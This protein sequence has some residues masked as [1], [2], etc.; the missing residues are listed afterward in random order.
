MKS[1]FIKESNFEVSVEKLFSWH[2]R[3][4]VIKRLTPCWESVILLSQ[5]GRVCENPRVFFKVKAGPFWID[6]VAKHVEYEKNR[7]FIDIQEKGPFKKYK[8]SHIFNRL[9][10][11]VSQLKDHVEFEMPLHFLTKYF[12]FNKF[13]RMFDYRHT[14]TRNDIDFLEKFNVKPMRIAVTGASGDIGRNLL[15][16]L[17]THG[18]KVIRLIRDKE[19]TDEENYYW[20]VDT[21][22]VYGSDLNFDAVIHLAGKPIGNK[23]W[24]DKIKGEIVKSRIDNTKKL[25]KFLLSLERKPRVFISASAIGYYGETGDNFVDEEGVSGNEFISYICKNWEDSANILKSSM[26]VVNLRIGVVMSYCG[27]ALNRVLPFFNTGLGVVFGKGDNYLSWVSMDDA[28]YSILFSLYKDNISG[29]VNVVSPN[30][31]RQKDYA[32][33]LAKVLNRPQFIKVPEKVVRLLFGDMGRE[34]LLTSTRVYP[35]KLLDNGFKFYFPDLEYTIR[36]TLGR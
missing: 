28:L 21:G 4:A 34:I 25:A 3:D 17:Q 6:Y 20:E 22:K 16:L 36:H 31:V 29:A 15:P 5:T 35:K 18:H 24:N 14:I 32:K 2:E 30:P 7:M 1:R 9:E 27:G 19:L 33:T 10:E 26:R 13:R 8:H 11:N 23:R 12:V